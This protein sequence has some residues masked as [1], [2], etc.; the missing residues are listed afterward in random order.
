MEILARKKANNEGLTLE[1]IEQQCNKKYKLEFDGNFDNVIE[2]FTT[3]DYSIDLINEVRN[4]S[5][6]VTKQFKLNKEKA[7]EGCDSE[8][9]VQ[10][11]YTTKMYIYGTFVT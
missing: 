9:G 4:K 11:Y 5:A 6:F 3:L 8:T 2:S 7:D 10:W 1:Q